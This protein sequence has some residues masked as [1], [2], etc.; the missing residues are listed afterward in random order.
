MA[1]NQIFNYED[2]IYFSTPEFQDKHLILHYQNRQQ[3]LSMC[4]NELG[5][6]HEIKFHVSWNGYH[7]KVIYDACYGIAARRLSSLLDYGYFQSGRFVADTNTL[8]VSVYQRIFVHIQ[9]SWLPGC[10]LAICIEQKRT[11][12]ELCSHFSLEDDKITHFI[13]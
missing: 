3:L 12:D 8:V 4:H 11:V 7:Y 6:S 9:Q 13:P 1:L 10:A 2:L 5:E